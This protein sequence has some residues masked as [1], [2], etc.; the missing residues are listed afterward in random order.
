VQGSLC[1]LIFLVSFDHVS[2]T[3]EVLT[4]KVFE[5]SLERPQP[6]AV[7][8]IEPPGPF[9]SLGNE[10]GLPEDPEIVGDGLPGDVEIGSDFSGSPLRIPDQPKDRPAL[11]MGHRL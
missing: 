3:V 7:G 10:T 5:Q 9:S 6:V 4:P 8:A 11:G 2:E 1:G